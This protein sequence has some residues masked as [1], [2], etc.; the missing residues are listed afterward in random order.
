M[1]YTVVN[2]NQR[3][4]HGVND[5][6]RMV[7]AFCHTEDLPAKSRTCD[8]VPRTIDSDNNSSSLGTNDESAHV[9]R[10]TTPFQIAPTLTSL[11][12]AGDNRDQYPLDDHTRQH[13]LLSKP[14]ATSWRVRHLQIA[15]TGSAGG[16]F[17]D[18]IPNLDYL[19]FDNQDFSDLNRN[20]H[21]SDN[22]RSSSELERHMDYPMPPSSQPYNN[23]TISFPGVN[24]KRAAPGSWNSLRSVDEAQTGCPDSINLSSDNLKSEEDLCSLESLTDSVELEL[25]SLESLVDTD[26]VTSG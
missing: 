24:G 7:G 22:I 23:R 6:S 17:V 3:Q 16:C 2:L 9:R 26:N 18:G 25:P 12:G 14:K 19:S 15:P 1:L 11:N 8:V 4:A 13:A 5:F 21:S 20:Y 10:R